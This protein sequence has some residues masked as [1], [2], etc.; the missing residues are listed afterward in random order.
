M[1]RAPL[2]FQEPL[3]YQALKVVTAQKENEERLV[4]R[5]SG[6]PKETLV[7][8]PFQTGD[9]VFGKGLMAGILD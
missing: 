7:P 1:F 3:A 8:R 9:N 6:D 5:E 2:A 4:P